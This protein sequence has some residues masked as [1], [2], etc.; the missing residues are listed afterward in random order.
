MLKHN[1]AYTNGVRLHYV[2]QGTGPLILLCH[3]WPESW[4][5]WRHQINALAND[6]YRVVAPDQRGYGTS[7]APHAVD[8]YGILDLVGDLVGLVHA[9]GEET[10]I[11]IGHDWGSMVAAPAA[12]LRPDIFRAVGLLSVPY[13]PRRA[14]RPAMRFETMSQK[15]HFYQAYFQ[16]VGHIEKELEEDYRKTILGVLYTASGDWSGHGFAV[17]DKTTRLVD[18]LAI[19]PKLPAWLTED[20]I[21]HYVEQFRASGFRGPINWYRNMDRNWAL[22]AFLDGAKLSQ[23]AIFIAGEKD[24]V[25]KIAAE[26]FE[27]LERNVPNLTKKVV[28]PGAGHW[29]QQERPSEVS[30]LLISFV[31]GLD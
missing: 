2:E 5:S 20:D 3:G 14:V 30:D 31:R 28:I 27:A 26:E 1:H 10:A 23:P 15:K 19:P 24:G 18:N 9:L 8:A 16:P 11:I 13:I 25:L 22:T 29:I 17:F 12:L 4:Y 6:G 21:A 7:D